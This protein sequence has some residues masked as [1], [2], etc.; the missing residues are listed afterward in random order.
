MATGTSARIPVSRAHTTR[1]VRLSL[2]GTFVL[3]EASGQHVTIA[4][5]R[6][7]SLVAYLVLHRGAAQPRRQIASALWP[8]S[9]EAQAHNSLRQLVH[10]LRRAWPDAHQL[11]DV[12]GG[13]LA[14]GTGADDGPDLE[15]D[16]DRYEM[17]VA[18]ALA[19]DD[20]TDPGAARTASEHAADLYRGAFLTGIDDEWVDDERGRLS[21]I[22]ER[23]LDRLI[24]LLERAGDYGAA[25]ERAEQR[26]RI[27]PDRKST[28]L[29][30]SHIQKSRMPSSA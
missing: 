27:D 14:L 19:I 10:Q 28:R 29:N 5:P 21:S 4:S 6:A 15:V 30:S 2:L 3:T 25:I 9:S 23:V 7:Q 18:A 11:L 8:D 13:T 26:L 16:V 17:A 22:H 20:N 1:P 12:R 24:G